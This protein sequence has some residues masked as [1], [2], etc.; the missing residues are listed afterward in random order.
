MK[1]KIELILG[2]FLGLSII[3]LSLESLS[4]HIFLKEITG[5]WSYGVIFV[6]FCWFIS[7]VCFYLVYK[8][9]KETDGK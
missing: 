6:P 7:I 4:Q 5:K 3:P 2:T 9:W 8:L 1:N